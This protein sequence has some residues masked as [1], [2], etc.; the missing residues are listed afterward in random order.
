MRKRVAAAAAAMGVSVVLAGCGGP[1]GTAEPVA[2]SD[3]GYGTRTVTDCTGTTATFTAAPTRAAAV[4]TSVVEFLLTLGLKDRIVGM[5]AQAPGAFPADLATMAE[6]IP[7]LGG[8][9]VP[10]NF[11]PVQREQLLSAN[12]DFVVG[13]WPS[14]FD[15]T[16]GA[17]S[18]A[19]LTERGLN[20]YFAF[21]ASCARTAPVTD[22]SVVYQ[23][24]ENY[25]TIFDVEEEAAALVTR[26]KD[27][28]ARVRER[29]K[30]A[31]R[32]KVFSYSWEDGGGK[33]YAVGNQNLSNAIIGQAGGKNVFDD[34]A[35]VYG[36]VSWE[37]VAARNP[38]VIVIEVFGK[39]TQAE[40]D[41]V[42]AKAKTFFTT[43]P[44]LKNVT[45]VKNQAFVPVLAETYYLGGVRNAEAVEKLATVLH[46]A[47]FPQ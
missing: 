24:I 28:V 33:A 27:T 15:S 32:P 1:S 25:G 46:P 10:G 3:A 35:A 21:A 38:D 42:V 39:A 20:S 11:V 16:K 45:A 9:Y 30:D 34:V 7:R 8:T 14:N 40:F 4:T 23:D 43:D 6:S 36:E 17:L 44:A 5:Q 22:L 13:G 47:A 41:A 31:P 18:Q 12:P 37:Q 29:T 2:S 19:E 26:M